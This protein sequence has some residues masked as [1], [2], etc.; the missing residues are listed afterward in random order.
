[1]D[2]PVLPALHDALVQFEKL[3][4][5]QV[6]QMGVFCASHGSRSV[7]VSEDGLLAKHD[8]LLELVDDSHFYLQKNLI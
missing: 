7:T 2:A 6:G 4:F 3:M 5:A 8:A 1:M